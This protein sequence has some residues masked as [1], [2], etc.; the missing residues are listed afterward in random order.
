MTATLYVVPGSHPSMAGRLMLEHKGIPY[1]RVDLIPALHKP[2]LRG[3][4]FRQ[5]TVP[6]LRLDGRRIQ[7]TLEISRA[8]EALQPEPALFPADPAARAATDEAE[9]WG[10]GVLQPIPRRLS[11]WALRRDRSAL[12]SF[13]E[14]ARLHVPL[15]LAVRT[16]KPL[17]WAEARINRADD[18]AIRSDLAALPGLLDRVDELLA[19]GVLGGTPPTAADYQ[20]ATSVRLLLC[21]DDLRERIDQRS[22]G[23]H[24]RE[25]VP[26]FP[27]RVPAVIP[28]AW[29][30]AG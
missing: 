9:A 23:R 3:L 22:A 16:A 18:E 7:G 24:A 27:G 2:I 1:R 13:A 12:L 11:W 4:G 10:E 15:G 25:L 17:V 21:F 8:L 14:G 30:A 6:A 19:E 5:T 28:D 29:I 20:I 26:V